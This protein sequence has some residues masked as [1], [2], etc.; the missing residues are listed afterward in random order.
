MNT[1][2]DQPK[3]M[4]Y[5]NQDQLP[6]IKGWKVGEEHELIV[7]VCQCSKSESDYE[8]EGE[9]ETSG[10][11]EIISMKVKGSKPVEEMTEKEFARHAAKEKRRTY[12]S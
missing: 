7:K 11:F 10:S 9:I 3:Q 4:I 5:I 12:G 6:E 8:G 2:S 1:H